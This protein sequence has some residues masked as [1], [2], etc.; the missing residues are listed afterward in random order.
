MRTNR[1]RTVSLIRT[2]L[3]EINNLRK[4]RYQAAYNGLK[5]EIKSAK[6]LFGELEYKYSKRKFWWPIS[7]DIFDRIKRA[8]YVINDA[9]ALTT[10]VFSRKPNLQNLHLVSTET[11]K[12]ENE[13]FSLRKHRLALAQDFMRVES[14]EAEESCLLYP[15]IN[16]FLKPANSV[17]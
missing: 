6:A 14:F 8:E 12:L 16:V 2:E 17:N 10:W 4:T 7:S 3:S 9:S 1:A 15:P 5:N 13:F 11:T